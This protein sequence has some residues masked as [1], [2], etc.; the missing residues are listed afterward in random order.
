MTSRSKSTAEAYESDGRYS[1]IIFMTAPCGWCMTSEHNGCKSQL[2]WNSKL[3]LCGCKSCDV[4]SQFKNLEQEE[5]QEDNEEHD[6][7]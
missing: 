4:H 3:Y 7:G 1:E 2:I 5:E 6:E